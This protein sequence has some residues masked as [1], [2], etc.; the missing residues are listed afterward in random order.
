MSEPL[1]HISL[2][3]GIGGIDLAAEWA[4]FETIAQVE[5]NEYCQRVLEKHWPGVHRAGEIRDFPDREYGA[6]TL[7]SGG[8]P[9]Q[10]FSAA[11]KRRGTKDDR[12]LWPEMLRV[13][14]ELAPAWVLAENVYGLLSIES[15]LVFESV[16][17][18]LEGL[19]YTTQ[20]VVIPAA[21]VGA[22]HLRYRVFVVG[23]TAEH[24]CRSRRAEPAGQSRESGTIDA[25]ADVAN[26]KCKGLEG[27]HRGDR[28][29]SEL[30]TWQSR[31]ANEGDWLVKSGIRR[32]S[33][34]ISHRV[35]RLRCLGNAVV[36]QQVYPILQAIREIENE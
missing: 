25:S 36:P 8:F 18:D 34:G 19:G 26:S 24:G 30:F 16:L 33:H 20:A 14:R 15:G 29:A 28:G 4:G 21:G 2:F 35:D 5:K 23:H 12:H 27:W 11:G 10:P 13:I 9:C 7:V 3:S 6:V 22:P 17:A 31:W 1:T 32:V